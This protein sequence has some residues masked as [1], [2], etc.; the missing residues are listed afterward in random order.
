MIHFY[1]E[2]ANKWIIWVYENPK[3]CETIGKYTNS[4]SYLKTD[5]DLNRLN[6]TKDL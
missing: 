1:N 6:A 2:Y 4:K 3:N 5:G